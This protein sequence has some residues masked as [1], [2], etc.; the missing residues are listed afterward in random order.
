MK[1]LIMMLLGI[2]LVGCST[3]AQSL[4]NVSEERASVASERNDVYDYRHEICF[5]ENDVT[6]YGNAD[7]LYKISDPQV[8]LEHST[9][10]FVGYVESVDGCTAVD[11]NGI[12]YPFTYTYGTIR[13]IENYHGNAEG[14]II[15]YRDGGIME[16]EEYLE[17]S[18]AEMSSKARSMM[19][20]TTP[21]YIKHIYFNDVEIEA[22]KTYLFYAV[23][24][25]DSEIYR[26]PHMQYGMCEITLEQNII[27]PDTKS[28]MPLSDYIETYID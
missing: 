3:Q 9:N 13:V 15:Y 17:L 14:N 28:E 10:V 1:K 7:L 23:Y 24:D 11:V 5:S 26:L 25:S 19:N 20:D 12:Y 27:D 21:R 22:G 4:V 18:P 6:A 2:S 16:L 8:L